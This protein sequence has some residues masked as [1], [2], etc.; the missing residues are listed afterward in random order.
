MKKY[1]ITII[2]SLFTILSFSQ[3]IEYPRIETDPLG[4]KVLIMTIDQAQKI[5]NNL[6][7]LTLLEKQGVQCDSLNTAYLKVIDN[8]NNQVKLLELNVKTL[9]EQINDKDKQISNLQEQLANEKASNNLCEDQ[10]KNK[11]EEIKLLKKEVR[12]QKTQKIVG[13]IVG[14][15]GV[16]GGIV[17]AVL[18]AL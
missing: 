17:L 6:E 8:L 1:I 12:K 14:G 16:I 5:D 3:T 11:D 4:N 10:K 15:L 13:F 9:K 18:V 7:L 2:L